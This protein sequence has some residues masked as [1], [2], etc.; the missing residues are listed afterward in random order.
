[1]PAVV[2]AGVVRFVGTIPV[3]TLKGGGE[4]YLYIFMEPRLLTL[5]EQLLFHLR[6]D[7]KLLGE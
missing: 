4:Y 3:D 5:L 1:M 6:W 2:G 7:E